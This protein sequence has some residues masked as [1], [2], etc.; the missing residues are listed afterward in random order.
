MFQIEGKINEQFNAAHAVPYYDIE[1]IWDSISDR[2]V[3]AH[4]YDLF[5]E[6]CAYIPIQSWICTDTRVGLFAYFFDQEFVCISYQPYR[7][8][9][10]N[11][12]WKSQQ[13]RDLV[14]A[15]I[16]RNCV[17]P[18]DRNLLLIN[19]DAL[20]KIEDS[21]NGI[22]VDREWYEQSHNALG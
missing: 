2:T 3:W 22:L 9:D 7:K 19:K 5:S 21:I 10:I 4:N 14:K 12:Y 16:E 6:H 13:S 8:S 18:D 17:N 11:F 1:Q 20:A 15:F